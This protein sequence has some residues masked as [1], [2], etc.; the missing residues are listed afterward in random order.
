MNELTESEIVFDERYEYSSNGYQTLYSEDEIFYSIYF[1]IF[2]RLTNRQF[3][4]VY[5]VYKERELIN[6]FYLRKEF[7]KLTKEDFDYMTDAKIIRTSNPK[8]DRKK[9]FILPEEH[10]PLF[11]NLSNEEGDFPILDFLQYIALGNRNKSIFPNE[12][13][14]NLV[15]NE[16][17][18]PFD[19]IYCLGDLVGDLE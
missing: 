15:L 12:L 14:T 18:T 8:C 7:Q 10:K 11:S 3:F 6:K 17:Q 19:S 1:C 2:A 9:L 16:A 5:F 13:L 4:V